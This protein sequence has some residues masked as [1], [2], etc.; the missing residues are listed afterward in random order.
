MPGIES[1]D[2]A[3]PDETKSLDKTTF[4]LVGLAGGQIQR[5]TYQSGYRWS[6]SIGAVIGADRCQ[7]EHIGYVA[8]GQLHVEHD[9]GSTGEAKAGEAFR[10]APGHDAWVVG[11]EPVVLIEFQG[12]LR[13][14][15]S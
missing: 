10:I 9:D 8:S 14:A 11:D 2:F 12:M 4:E 5:T 6:E 3:Q 15:E 7:V 13:D 1:R